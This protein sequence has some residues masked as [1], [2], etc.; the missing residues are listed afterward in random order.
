MLVSGGGKWFIPFYE[1]NP[2]LTFTMHCEP[3]F[4][5]DPDGYCTVYCMCV[6]SELFSFFWQVKLF[7]SRFWCLKNSELLLLSQTTFKLTHPLR[8][9]CFQVSYTS[10]HCTIQRRVGWMASSTHF[11]TLQGGK[12]HSCAILLGDFWKRL[13]FFHLPNWVGG[14]LFLPDRKRY[15]SRQKGLEIFKLFWFWMSFFWGCLFGFQPFWMLYESWK[16]QTSLIF[17]WFYLRGHQWLALGLHKFQKMGSIPR[18]GSWG[19]PAKRWQFYRKAV[20]IL[21]EQIDVSDQNL[22]RKGG[23]QGALCSKFILLIFYLQGSYEFC[24][25]PTVDGSEIHKNHPTCMKPCK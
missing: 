19:N 11:R 17:G 25:S 15:P 18:L 7:K 9:T 10:R 14:V 23:L 6:A 12:L 3:M 16:K 22:W 20:D 4:L 2:F 21:D 8:P 1:G 5:Q 24:Q 13:D